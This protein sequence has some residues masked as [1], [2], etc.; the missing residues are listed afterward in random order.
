MGDTILDTICE[1]LR[2]RTY[3]KGSKILVDGS[4]IEKMVFI[5]RGKMSNGVETPL[6]EGDVC[7]EELLAWCIENSS[8]NKGKSILINTR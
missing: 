5:V 3:I 2:Q 4:L 7:G 1:R 6:G 8:V